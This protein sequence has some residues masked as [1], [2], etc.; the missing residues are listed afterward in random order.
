MAV[1]FL[2]LA[3]WVAFIAMLILWPAGTLAFPGAWA[4]I[5]LFAASGA[6]MILWL[7]KHSPSLLRE[8]M[9]SP[10]QRGQ[11]LWDR[12]FLTLFMLG[13]LGWLAFMGWDAARTGF[14]AIPPWLQILG[15][16]GVLLNILG[17]LADISREC[18]CCTRGEDSRRPEGDR[19]RSLCHCAAPDVCKRAIS[20]H[21]HSA[22]P[23]FV[24]GP[25]DLRNSHPRYRLARGAGG[26]HVARR[27]AGL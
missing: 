26:T 23:R 1:Y 27:T 9:A 13:F 24:A 18:L 17:T 25:S 10:V 12:M 14:S 5:G 7:S 3:A 22:A 19:H 20:L 4:F 21:W 11:K 15:G 16:F 2:Q 8:R 6:I